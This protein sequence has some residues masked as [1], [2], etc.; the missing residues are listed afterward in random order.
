MHR[1]ET[2]DLT[3]APF[4]VLDLLFDV[5]YRE[6]AVLRQDDWLHVAHGGTLLIARDEEGALFGVARLMPAAGER[7]RQI[8]QVAVAPDRRMCGVGTAL[9]RAAEA[10]AA[11][12]GAA[13]VWLNAR[14]EAIPFYE[15]VGFVC[16]GDPFV[17]ELTRI[18]HRRMVKSLAGHGSDI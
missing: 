7:S 4:G 9:V 13:E 14:D 11:D 1:I 6:Y 5:L 16:V 8:R 3:E 2:I 12:Q 17:S 18:P 10:L 15:R